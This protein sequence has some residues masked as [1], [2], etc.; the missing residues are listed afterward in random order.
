MSIFQK[1]CF[2]Q[3]WHRKLSLINFG[4]MDMSYI[5]DSGQN[6]FE[7]LKIDWLSQ[8]NYLLFNENP[9][10]LPPRRTGI[11]WL[12][13]K[14]CSVDST[15]QTWPT[16]DLL[17]STNFPCTTF[18][19]QKTKLFFCW[20]FGK[21][22][23]VG[24]FTALHV[25]FRPPPRIWLVQEN[26]VKF[27]GGTKLDTHCNHERSGSKMWRGAQNLKLITMVSCV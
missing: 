5:M 17:W 26:S 8:R 6:W 9:G 24:F 11:S 19:L 14:M 15:T 27:R 3:V 10:F 1:T 22:D 2:L 25:K 13:W 12:A 4:L 16:F 18:F 23:V 7:L 21:P 20:N